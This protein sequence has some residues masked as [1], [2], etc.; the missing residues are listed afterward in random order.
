M[1]TRLSNYLIVYTAYDKNGSVIKDG[2]MRVK[3]KL[4]KFEAQCSF[5]EYL[6]KKCENFN[7]L[8]IHSCQD[9]FF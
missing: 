2:K 4:S 6:K 7:K 8:V 5:E 1:S 3:N 9:D